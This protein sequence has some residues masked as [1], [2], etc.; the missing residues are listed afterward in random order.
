MDREAALKYMEPVIPLLCRRVP[1]GLRWATYAS[2]SGNHTHAVFTMLGPMELYERL[3]WQACLG[4]DRIR[5][6]LNLIGLHNGVL[7]Q[8]VLFMPK[9]KSGIIFEDLVFETPVRRIKDVD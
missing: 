5:E 6:A 7:N 3:A 1:Q 9:D 4:S 8:V 2:K